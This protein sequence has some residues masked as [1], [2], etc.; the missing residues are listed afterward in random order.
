[1]LDMRKL[2]ARERPPHGD[3]DLKLCPGGLVDI[4]FAAQALQIAHAARGGP[5]V[6]G[7]GPA[8]TILRDEGLAEPEALN[9]LWAACSLEQNLQQ[10]LKLALP[11]GADPAVEPQ[12]FRAL[13]ARA[14]GCDS[15]QALTHTLAQ[16]R[17]DAHAAF[18]KVVK[19]LA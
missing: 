19:A 9:A 6:T 13:L 1:V 15:F 12:R 3:W 18:L 17:R 4:E 7:T 14:G 8:L 16:R 10:L 5:L 11:D 2:M